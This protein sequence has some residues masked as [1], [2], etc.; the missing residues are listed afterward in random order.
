MKYTWAVPISCNECLFRP[1]AR[2][3]TT[4]TVEIRNY[5]QR[6]CIP[7]VM[8]ISLKL[9]EETLIQRETDA[10][11]T[12]RCCKADHGEKDWSPYGHC[13]LRTACRCPCRWVLSKS[14]NPELIPTHPSSLLQ[15][16]RNTQLRIKWVLQQ[17]RYS[18]A[19]DIFIVPESQ[20]VAY[21]S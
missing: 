11:Q 3:Q 4:Q 2:F 13:W 1:T 18:R 12:A 10:K 21:K 7:K 15:G 8:T 19:P 6:G 9:L 5:R 14:C 16:Y 20:P 17:N